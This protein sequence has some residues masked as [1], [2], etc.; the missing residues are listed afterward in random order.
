MNRRAFL[1]TLSLTPIAAAVPAVE[2]ATSAPN[3]Y[4]GTVVRGMGSPDVNG[5]IQSLSDLRGKLIIFTDDIGRLTIGGIEDFASQTDT[6]WLGLKVVAG[7]QIVR[8]ETRGIS[9]QVLVRETS[10]WL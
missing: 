5:A 10:R 2:K 1:T 4:H 7:C 6:L 8:N 3:E 9:G